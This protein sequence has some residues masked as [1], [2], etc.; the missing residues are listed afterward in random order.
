M[1]NLTGHLVIGLT[2]SLILVLGFTTSTYL[3]ER[4]GRRRLLLF[5]GP[6]MICLL[7][8]IGCVLSLPLT[9]ATGIGLVSLG[10]GPIV[11]SEEP[12]DSPGACGSLFIASQSP[13]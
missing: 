2:Y 1:W 10:Y 5:A 13:R 9:S 11:M 12:A 3:V 7:L 4:V 8:L 6:A